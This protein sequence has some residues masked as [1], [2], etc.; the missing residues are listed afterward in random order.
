MKALHRLTSLVLWGLVIM[1]AG[2]VAGT[3][4]SSGQ[5]LNHADLVIVFPDGR[6]ETRC[7]LFEKEEISGAELLRRSGLST[8]FSKSGGFGEGVCRIDD[9]GCSDPGSCYCQCSGGDCAYWAYFALAESQWRFQNIGPSQRVIRDGDTD[10]WVWGAGGGP[11]PSAELTAACRDD[12]VTTLATP[13]MIPS[14]APLTTAAQP[15]VP[16]TRASLDDRPVVTR[17]ELTATEPAQVVG[18]MEDGTEDAE[19]KDVVQS[20]QAAGDDSG[21]ASVGLI[22]FGVVAAALVAVAVGLV[23]RRRAIG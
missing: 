3:G 16:P 9:T 12:A 17:V 7:V 1:L 8:V 15:T 5:D 11:P 19:S 18:K 20:A 23:L 21:G 22:A 2:M 13:R 10:A 6:V 14:A 4:A